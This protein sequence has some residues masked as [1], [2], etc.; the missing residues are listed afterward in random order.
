MGVLGIEITAIITVLIV[1]AGFPTGYIIA[2]MTEEEMKAGKKIFKIIL[3]LM[4]LVLT[5]E[6][7]TGALRG[8]APEII[9]SSSIT[10]F[11][12]LLVL[13]SVYYIKRNKI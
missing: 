8:Y 12:I 9:A 6:M 7:I 4:V 3:P 11:L 2:R 13:G 5:G 1:I 10:T